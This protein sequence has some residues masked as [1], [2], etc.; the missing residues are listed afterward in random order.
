MNKEQ[1]VDKM[2]VN[3]KVKTTRSDELAIDEC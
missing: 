3:L 2:Q 1:V